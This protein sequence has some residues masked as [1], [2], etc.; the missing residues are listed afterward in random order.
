MKIAVA[1]GKGGTGKTTVSVNLYRTIGKFFDKNIRLVD[2]DVEEPND[3]IFFDN[4]KLIEKKEVHQLIPK[5]DT[6]KCTFCHKCADWC[7]FNAITIVKNLEFAEVNNDL[8]HSCGACSVACEF[9]AITEYPQP[10]GVISHFDTGIGNGLIEGRLEIGS[11]MQTSLI[12]EVKKE[13]SQNNSTIIFDAPPG[14]S[15]PV[16]E[17]VSDVDYIVLVTEPTPFGLH[18]LKITVELLKDL[19][20]PFGVIVNKA[21]LGS[22][23]VYSYLNKQNIEFLSDI[24]FVKEYA[25]NYA[26]GKIFE[27]IPAEIEGTYMDIAEELMSKNLPS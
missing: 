22:D 20:K 9:D 5:I 25:A 24:P 12:K 17:T 13:V 18:D 11:A 23:D 6:T 21:G 3:A 15:C 14:T 7:E 10:L 16:V 8:C 27:N 19:K 4:P 1:S 26:S 2:C